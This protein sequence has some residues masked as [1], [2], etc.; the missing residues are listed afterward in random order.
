MPCRHS[1]PTDNRYSE[2]WEESTVS[3]RSLNWAPK[4]QWWKVEWRHLRYFHR[5]L[6]FTGPLLGFLSSSCVNPIPSLWEAVCCCF[7]LTGG[8]CCL[9]IRPEAPAVCK[10]PTSR[11]VDESTAPLKVSSF[12]Q[13]GE[14]HL[15]MIHRYTRSTQTYIE[16]G[17]N[18]NYNV[19]VLY[20][21]FKGWY[22]STKS[23]L[24]DKVVLQG[25]FVI[26]RD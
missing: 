25:L 12:V 15:R 4:V 21:H 18:L 6:R 13:S 20:H 16:P 14:I 3:F 11:E 23:L 26:K 2:G 7:T 22:G 24:T 8:A 1:R 19:F 5:G 9:W 17:V 10:P